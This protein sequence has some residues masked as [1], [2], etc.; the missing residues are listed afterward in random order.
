MNYDKPEVRVL[1]LINFFDVPGTTSRVT[2]S[3]TVVA[4]I[5]AVDD[6]KA[7]RPVKRTRIFFLDGG[8]TEI[9]I[10]DLDL[11]TLEQAVGSYT[12]GY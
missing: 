10:S 8:Q 11:F 4:A 3:P 7:G 12:I 6:E 2:V 9:W 5:E 1:T